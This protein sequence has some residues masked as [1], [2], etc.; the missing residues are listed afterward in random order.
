MKEW[1]RAYNKAC[2]TNSQIYLQQYKT[3]RSQ[4]S[5]ALDTSKNAFIQQKLNNASSPAAKWRF[6]NTLNISK[7]PLP[8]PFS[9]FLPSTLNSHYASIVNKSPPLKIEDLNSIIRSHQLNP[10]VPNFNFLPV[11]CSDIRKIISC[12]TSKGSG[13]DGISTKMLKY[14]SPAILPCMMNIINQSFDTGIFPN[15]WKKALL[16]PLAKK[17]I[18]STPSDTRPI[19]KLSELS[20]LLERVHNHGSFP[21][22]WIS[23]S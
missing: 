18:L 7:T 2:N 9:S 21:V 4:V 8:S 14:S 20:K 5:N 16:M 6:L 19:V 11:N 1:D 10:S 13:Y 22:I 12:A 15:D 23:T 17:K 3:L